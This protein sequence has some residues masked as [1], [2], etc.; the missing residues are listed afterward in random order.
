MDFVE[1]ELEVRTLDVWA[2]C[3]S[4]IVE[5]IQAEDVL[6]AKAIGGQ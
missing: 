2:C 5:V 4:E 3:P 1:P 6:G